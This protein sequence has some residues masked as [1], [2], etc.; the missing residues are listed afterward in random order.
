MRR[1]GSLMVRGSAICFNYQTAEESTVTKK[2]EELAAG[3]GEQMKAAYSLDELEMILQNCGFLIYEHLN[4]EEIT[5][6][7]FGD[8]NAK[9]PRHIMQAPEGVGYILAVREK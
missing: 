1:I 9:N 7:Y 2:N 6:Q 4:H 5:E 8:Y 3:T